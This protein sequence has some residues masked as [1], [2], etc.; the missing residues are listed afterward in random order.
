MKVPSLEEHC[1]HTGRRYGA[2]GRD[3]HSWMDEPSQV[4]GGSHREFRHDL[5]SLPIA[6]RIFQSKY[7]AEMV[8]NIF[9]DHLR[10]DSKEMRKGQKSTHPPWSWSFNE[11]RFLQMNF[12]E[13]VEI[14]E[15]Y[16]K[17]KYTRQDIRRRQKYLGII[18]PRIFRYK[19]ARLFKMGFRLKYGQSISM[20]IKVLKGG[21]KDIDFCIGTSKRIGNSFSFQRGMT[22]IVEELREFKYTADFTGVHWFNF[23]NLFS[24]VTTKEVAVSFHLEQGK[25]LSLNFEV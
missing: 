14:L 2:E 23:S 6:I 5:E 3:I 12:L 11:D 16:F 25:L 8:E 18:R 20:H 22:R 9:L 17:G 7:G 4:A 10:A 24:W 21:N 15:P 19:E 1:K 13:K